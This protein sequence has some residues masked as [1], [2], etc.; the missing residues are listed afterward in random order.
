MSVFFPTKVYHNYVSDCEN[1]LVTVT[2]TRCMNLFPDVQIKH[3][4]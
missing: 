3:A 1:Q 4:S 2:F